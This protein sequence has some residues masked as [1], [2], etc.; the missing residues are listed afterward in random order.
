MKMNHPFKVKNGRHFQSKLVKAAYGDPKI[1]TMF[2]DNMNR[3]NKEDVTISMIRA[4]DF[5]GAL[6]LAFSWRKSNEG[7]DLWSD[8]YDNL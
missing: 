8:I 6:M 1:C 3:E 7:K 4:G 2:I 5:K